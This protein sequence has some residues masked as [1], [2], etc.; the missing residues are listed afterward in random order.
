MVVIGAKNMYLK[1]P[2]VKGRQHGKPLPIRGFFLNFRK[3]ATKKQRTSNT[4]IV[5]PFRRC[6]ACWSLV[7]R[8]PFWTMCSCQHTTH[9]MQSTTNSCWRHCSCGSSGKGWSEGRGG[10]L[11]DTFWLN[12]FKMSKF[13]LFCS[14]TTDTFWR[15]NMVL[16]FV[17][18]LCPLA[19]ET[20]K[21]THSTFCFL[22]GLPFFRA[23]YVYI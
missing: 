20:N 2:S 5:S 9:R 8:F 6:S 7:Q 22:L 4:K 19:V 11:L 21:I 14:G 17:L 10:R 18:A 15:H 12:M 3:G 23:W 13:E 16:F 1:Q